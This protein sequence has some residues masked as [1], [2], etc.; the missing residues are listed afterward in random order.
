MSTCKDIIAACVEMGVR[1]P[2]GLKKNELV[3][4]HDNLIYALDNGLSLEVSSEYKLPLPLYKAKLNFYSCQEADW[5]SHLEEHGWA[6]VPIPNL[7]VERMVDSFYNTLETCKYKGSGELT[8]FSRDAPATWTQVPPNV[9]GIFKNN[10]G[11]FDWQ[12]EIREKCK[13]IFEYLHSTTDLLVS[14]DGV[15]FAPPGKS[16]GG[17]WFHCD[18]GR[19]CRDFCSVQGVVTLTP[20]GPED[21]SL[22]VIE[23]SHKVF[24]EYL[25][26]Y[27]LSGFAWGYVNLSVPYWNHCL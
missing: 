11:H 8:T 15:R 26:K 6:T 9:H 27:P 4:F 16:M 19:F 22:V 1:P 10:F 21:G 12:W 14:F 20:A 23:G 25:E 18:Q 3:E 7:D 17:S 24:N 13:P 2:G 5:F